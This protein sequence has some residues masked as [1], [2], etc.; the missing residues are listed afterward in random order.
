MNPHVLKALLSLLGNL[1][2]ATA[3]SLFKVRNL[4]G[5]DNEKIMSERRRKIF[6]LDLTFDDEGE[7]IDLPSFQLQL[8]PTPTTLDSS[9]EMILETALEDYLTAFFEQQYPPPDDDAPSDTS[10]YFRSALVDIVGMKDISSNNSRRR[11]LQRQGSELDVKTTLWFD[12][13]VFPEYSTLD[14]D[15]QN[16]LVN[17]FDVFLSTYLPA[18]ASSANPELEAVDSGEYLSGFSSSPTAS[19]SQ[20]IQRDVSQANEGIET[21]GRR[22]GPGYV[23]FPAIGAGVAMFIITALILSSKRRRAAA[24]RKSGYYDDESTSAPAHISIDF[25]GR[26]EALELERERQEEEYTQ[27]AIA[28][29]LRASKAERY[30]ERMADGRTTIHLA[31]LDPPPSLLQSSSMSSDSN[32]QLDDEDWNYSLKKFEPRR[33]LSLMI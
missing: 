15:M 26:Q 10:P 4:Q 24:D 21:N 32:Q 6:E 8:F 27:Q 20:A 3:D 18:Y 5:V 1:S 17:N 9:S 14:S 28:R 33:H 2:L 22:G 11:Q 29:R 12:N 23:L 13:G 25:D 19:P 30:S 7:P 16:A 31:K